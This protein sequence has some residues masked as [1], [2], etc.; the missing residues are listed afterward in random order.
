MSSYDETDALVP[1]GVTVLRRPGVTLISASA[2]GPAVSPPS[3]PAPPPP[4]TSAPAAVAHPVQPQA[5]VTD[6]VAPP[7]VVVPQRPGITIIRPPAAAARPAPV[8]VQPQGPL[9]TDALVPRGVTVPERPEPYLCG[10]RGQYGEPRPRLDSWHPE[11]MAVLRHCQFVGKGGGAGLL[12]GN[13]TNQSAREQ[14]VSVRRRAAVRQ[15][16]RMEWN[17]PNQ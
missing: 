14:R 3:P 6:A 9:L 7:G 13:R 1:P 16:I 11:G 5:A 2:A 4:V 10:R 12:A 17:R 15:H 8:V